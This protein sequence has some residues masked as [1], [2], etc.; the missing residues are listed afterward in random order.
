M[1]NKIPI[2][3]LKREI[4]Y[5]IFVDAVRNLLC[6]ALMDSSIILIDDC[7]SCIRTPLYCV[8]LESPYF[9]NRSS[10]SGILRDSTNSKLSIRAVTAVIP[11]PIHNINHMIKHIDNRVIKSIHENLKRNSLSNELVKTVMPAAINMEITT[12]YLLAFSSALLM[13]SI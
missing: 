5:L 6:L 9:F 1:I 13:V 12:K 7:K 3:K 8:E 11:I 10:K 4:K 2:H